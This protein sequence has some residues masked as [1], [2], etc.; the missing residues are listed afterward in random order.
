MKGKHKRNDKGRQ[1]VFPG[2]HGGLVGVPAGQGR[3]G[4]RRQGGRGRN[5]GKDRVIEDEHVGGNL[6]DFKHNQG[7]RGDHGSDDIG[8]GNRDGQADDPHEQPGKNAGQEE[9][10]SGISDDDGTELETQA[11]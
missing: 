11:G 7:R 2:H 4:K 9:V 8:G 1:G 6:R 10:A 5:L 3:R